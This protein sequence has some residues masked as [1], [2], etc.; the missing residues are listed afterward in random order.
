MNP[1]ISENLFYFFFFFFFFTIQIH[2]M[3]STATTALATFA[4]GCFWGTEHFFVRKFK[5]ALVMHEVG[6]MGGKDAENVPYTEVKKGNTGHA[7]VLHLAYDTTK[8]SYEDLLTHFFRIHNST[9]LNRQEGDVGTQYRSAIFYHD[10]EQKNLAEAY[11]AKLNGGD[12][13]LHAAYAKA[14]GGAKCVTTLE[15]AGKFYKA[16]DYHQNYLEE[17]P[18]GYCAHRI[19]F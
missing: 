11:I 18:D 15:P 7:E 17:K 16:E 1:T 8:L 4:A 14:F 5:D 2:T 3:T 12:A 10:E 19:Y 6:F 9:T 13:Q